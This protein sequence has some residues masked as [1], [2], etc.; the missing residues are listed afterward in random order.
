MKR[1]LIYFGDEQQKQPIVE[2]VLKDMHADY[3][4]L[5]DAD[6]NQRVA[7]LMGLPGFDEIPDAKPAHHSID[8]M[9]FEQASDEDILLLNTLLQEKGAAMKRKAMLTEHNKSWI[10]HDLLSEIEREHTYFQT[11]DALRTLL[12]Q[13]SELVI[14]AYSPASWNRYEKA[15]YQA[16]AYLEKKC[17]QEELTA[18]YE[19]LSSAKKQLDPAG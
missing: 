1:I 7:N 3:R 6:L 4:I 11:M 19:A 14:E 18:A 10:F 5:K 9:L 16:Y 8:L 15:F 12:A 2:Q 17:S 13:S